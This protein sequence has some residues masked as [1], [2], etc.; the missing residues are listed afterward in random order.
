MRRYIFPL[1]VVALVLGTSCQPKVDVEKEKEAIMAVLV[2]ESEGMKAMDK[3]RVFDTHIRDNQETRLEMGVYGY[4]AYVGW[5]NIE[6]LLGDY[7]EG[8]PHPDQENYKEN[9]EI[10]VNGNSAWLTCDNVWRSKS[11]PG[12]IGYSN[13]QIVFLEKVKGKWKISFSAYYNKPVSVPGIDE[14]FN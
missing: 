7:L 10:K 9:V 5:D 4:N 6:S 2:E 3:D 13:I 11:A 14:P 8:T 12:E 1:F